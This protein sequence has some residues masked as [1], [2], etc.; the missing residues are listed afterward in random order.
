MKCIK[1]WV[2]AALLVLVQSCGEN[3]RVDLG[4][5]YR[6]D[7]DPVIS[8]DCAIFG[9]YENTYAI[10]GHVLKYDFDSKFIIAEQKPR[11]SILKDSY[12][13]P[14]MDIRKQEKIFEKSSIRQFWIINKTNDSI[15]GPLN[16]EEFFKKREELKVPD[17]LSLP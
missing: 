16:K 4:N 1:F 8:N 10:T 7:Y 5:G 15:Y 17:V 11:D 9:P 2:V 3:K 14:F 12:N 6:F 13:D